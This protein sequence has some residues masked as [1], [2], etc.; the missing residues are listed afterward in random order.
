[1]SRHSQERILCN[2]SHCTSARAICNH[3]A[4]GFS[5]PKFLTWGGTFFKYAI[6]RSAPTR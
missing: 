6:S 5:R 3:A 1:M 4:Y 2:L